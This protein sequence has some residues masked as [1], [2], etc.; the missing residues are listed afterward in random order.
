MAF[1]HG[2]HQHI[3]VYDARTCDELQRDEAA[4][5]YAE[6]QAKPFAELT[7]EQANMLGLCH[8]GLSL[9]LCED[10]FSHYYMDDVERQMRGY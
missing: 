8:H 7:R 5:R 9:S 4:A 1:Y 2:D 6:I 3:N 10:E